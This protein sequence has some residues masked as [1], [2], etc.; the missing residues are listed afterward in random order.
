[1]SLELIDRP[2]DGDEM[3]LFVRGFTGITHDFGRASSDIAPTVLG[4]L[5][6]LLAGEMVH[7]ACRCNRREFILLSV[8]RHPCIARE[9]SAHF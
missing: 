2:I 9:A 4:R 5:D 8:R 6:D 1:M 7:A 3:A